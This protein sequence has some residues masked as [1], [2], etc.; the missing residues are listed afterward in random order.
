MQLCVPWLRDQFMSVRSYGSLSRMPFEAGS[1]DDPNLP[2]N[3]ILTWPSSA[4][5]Q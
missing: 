1:L 3:E 5:L 2:R 4:V